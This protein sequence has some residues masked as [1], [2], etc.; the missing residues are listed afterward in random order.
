MIF[1]SYVGVDMKETGLAMLAL[2][3][4]T[5]AFPMYGEYVH[6]VSL[7]IMQARLIGGGLILCGGLSLVL[8]PKA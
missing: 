4:L 3:C 2:G 7:T 1:V 8:A 5:L 6:F